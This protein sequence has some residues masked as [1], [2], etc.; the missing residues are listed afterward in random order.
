MEGQV[1]GCPLPTFAVRVS[2]V[3]PAGSDVLHFLVIKQVEIKADKSPSLSEQ[4]M[5]VN[6]SSNSLSSLLIKSET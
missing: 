6:I 4:E 2:L 5:K 1:S 3:D